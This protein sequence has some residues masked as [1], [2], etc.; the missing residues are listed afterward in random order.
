M[1][2][3]FDTAR[4]KL[5]KSI[6]K[7]RLE[8]KEDEGLKVKQSLRSGETLEYSELCGKHKLAMKGK[9]DGDH[10]GRIYAILGSVTKAGEAAISKLTG[11]DMSV[12]ECLG[13]L[14]LQV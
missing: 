5:I 12:A 10:F 3:Q 7:G 14:F 2:E 6:M 8:I 11:V 13:F 9:K 1:K 4:N